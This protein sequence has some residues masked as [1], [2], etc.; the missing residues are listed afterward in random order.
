[1]R[2]GYESSGYSLYHYPTTPGEVSEFHLMEMGIQIRERTQEYNAALNNL[3]TKVNARTAA[4]VKA[5]ATSRTPP[6]GYAQAVLAVQ[7][8]TEAELR[9][10]ISSLQAKDSLLYVEG[11]YHWGYIFNVSVSSKEL[12]ESSR[13]KIAEK[14][15]ER[16]PVQAEIKEKQKLLAEILAEIAK[17]TKDIDAIKKGDVPE[18]YQVTNEQQQVLDAVQKV[19]DFYATITKELGDQASDRAK[20]LQNAAK[21]KTIRS[22]SEALAAW[23]KY[24]AAI[25]KKLSAI[26]RAAID[27]ALNGLTQEQLSAQLT[28]FSKAFGLASKAVDGVSVFNEYRQAVKT[29]NWSPFFMKIESLLA[30]AAALHLVSLVFSGMAVTPMGLLAFA[31]LLAA[32]SAW[33]DDTLLK[34]LNSWILA[35]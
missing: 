25:D 20:M 31:L 3:A 7:K 22:A 28:T 8:A 24:G 2:N 16:I 5:T 6:L 15:A 26:D 18:K 13:K 11:D 34:D 14:E 9:A 4:E 33:V 32:T 17:T 30:G 27:N 21:G 12:V 1:M 35:N 29:G 23:D 10:E 19:S